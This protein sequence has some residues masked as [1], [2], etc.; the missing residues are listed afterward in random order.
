MRCIR[1]LHVGFGKIFVSSSFLVDIGCGTKYFR[2]YGVNLKILFMLARKLR[3]LKVRVLLIKV[4]NELFE[5]FFS[6]K[7]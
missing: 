7:S 4:I 3:K 1:K 5:I 2:H 6:Y